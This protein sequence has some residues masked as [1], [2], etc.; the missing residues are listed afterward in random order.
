MKTVSCNLAK[1]V[2]TNT[3]LPFVFENIALMGNEGNE[4]ATAGRDGVER[5]AS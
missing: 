4:S 5:G 1:P 3:E 2:I